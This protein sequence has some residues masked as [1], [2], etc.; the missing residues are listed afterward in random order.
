M[1]RTLSLSALIALLS[2][3]SLGAP[4][5]D[6]KP[7]AEWPQFRG[8]KR[9]GLS[10][11]KG[12]LTEW[13]EK[14][15]PLVWKAT[16]LG[17]GFSSISLVDG[18]IFTMGDKDGA[19]HVFAVS[20]KDGSVLWTSEKLGKAGGN[21]AG[22]RCTPTVD[23][24]LVYAL[25]QFGDLVCLEAASGKER[26]RKNLKN[27]FKG[28]D[29]RWNYCESVLIDGD[30]LVCTPH[31][32]EA[33]MLALNKK[34]GEVI[35]KSPIKDNGGPSYSSMVISEACGIRQYV[36]L[37]SNG[38]VGIRAK[39]GKF[40]WR[41]DGKNGCFRG[42]TANVPTPIVEGNL[43][44]VSAGYGKGGGLIELSQSDGKVSVKE[45]YFD[46]N[47]NNRHGGIVHVGDYIYGDRDH[48]GQP[49]CAEWKTGKNTWTK[50]GESKG[51]GSIA[52]TYADGH[53]YCRYANG[54]VALVEANPDGYQERGGFKIPNST[55]NSWNHPVVVGGRLYLRDKD[56]LWCYDVTKH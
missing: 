48:N 1:F 52:V 26:W 12:L 42:N 39:D 49:W 35:W 19:S 4:A 34:T 38:V 56:I 2:S 33:T 18:R 45:L 10:T 13:S 23:G 50:R 21:Y 53:L 40:L 36:Q 31:G 17:Q 41:Y 30:K 43:V 32:N 46:G 8:P 28:T 15:P 9:D 22:T 54:Y 16:G 27:D 11:D 3:H 55:S 6:A 47:L 44:F 29:A 51:S 25:G 5:P 14:G 20:A 24:D 7:A 37:L